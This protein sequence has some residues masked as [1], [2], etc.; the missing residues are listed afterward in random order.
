MEQMANLQSH[1]GMKANDT[2]QSQSECTVAQTET[3][4]IHGDHQYI[5]IN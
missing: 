1:G 4:G 3:P 2:K 5:L